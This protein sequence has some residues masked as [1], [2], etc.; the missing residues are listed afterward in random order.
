M[1]RLLIAEDEVILALA[2]RAQLEQRGMEI[3]GL[4]TNGREVLAQCQAARPDVVLM[5]VRMPETDGVEGTRLIMQHCPTCVIM[6]TAFA[7]EGTRARAEAAGAMGF[8]TKPIQALGVLEEM[9]RARSRFA[10]FEAIRVES[11]DL[12]EALRTRALVEEAKR[13]LV[14]AGAP[15]EVSF[16]ALRE[17]AERGGE[18]LRSAAE[19]VIA[20]AA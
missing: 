12:E 2:M 20:G 19:A 17:R 8:L 14:A 18:P 7:D 1:W 6:V 9:P 16:Q 10:E 15:P 11:Q 3:V 13:V 4:A 5:D